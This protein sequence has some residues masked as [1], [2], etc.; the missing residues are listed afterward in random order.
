M[1][2]TKKMERYEK[3][4]DRLFFGILLILY[5]MLMFVLFYRQAIE[6]QGIYFSD[7]KAY[8]LETQGL[9]SGYE[10]PY[11]F[12]FW[13]SRIWMPVMGAEAAVAFSTTFLNS[14]SVLLLKYYMEKT[15]KEYARR[16]QV[17]WN[18]LWDAAVNLAVF[19]LFFV[20]M[21]YGPKDEKI[22]GYQ[23]IYRCNGILTPNPY[24]N[25]TYLAVRP[26]SII[27]FFLTAEILEK[28]E[29]EIPVKKAVYL[30]LFSFLAAFTKPSFHFILLPVVGLTLLYRLLAARFANWKN[31]L[32][33]GCCFLP[34][35]FLLVFQFLGVFTGQN[36]RGEE[37][38]IGIELGKAW[39]IHSF[40]IPLSI[41]LALLFPFC[42]LALNFREL[43]KDSQF[44]LAWQLMAAGLL[45]FLFLYEK[46]FRLVHL[47]FSW[48][49]MHGLFFVF[50]ICVLR[51]LKNLMGWKPWIFGVFVI[52]ELYLYLYHLQ[53]GIEFFLYLYQGNNAGVF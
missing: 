22:W 20:S 7:M 50:V 31:T 11:R 52:P 49:Y 23:Y 38:G 4:T 27:C 17:K 30:S 6:Y 42:I 44:R 26:F 45:S 24:W 14:L 47:N 41:L 10:F 33:F 53:C 25:A 28:Y 9:E 40:N 16:Q 51:M 21:Y 3:R 19:S 18:L 32:L 13:L 39:H 36:V 35:G 12:F 46:G 48:G 37:T 8:I 29:R 15:L 43:K 5:S 34:T 1:T 2:L